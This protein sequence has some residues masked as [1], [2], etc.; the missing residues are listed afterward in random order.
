MTESDVKQKYSK[1]K[2][3]NNKSLSRK[4]SVVERA[5]LEVMRWERDRQGVLREL[6]M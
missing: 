1:V 3:M 5:L 2:N 6:G 4:A